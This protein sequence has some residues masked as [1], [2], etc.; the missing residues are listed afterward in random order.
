MISENRWNARHFGT[1]T[2]RH[3][4]NSASQLDKSTLVFFL[5]DF[6]SFDCYRMYFTSCNN[7]APVTNLCH[8][9]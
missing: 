4:D 6:T 2:N 5:F 7:V 9:A 8:G 1:K 3:P